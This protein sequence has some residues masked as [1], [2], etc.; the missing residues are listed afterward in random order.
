MEVFFRV[1]EKLRE[2]FFS[3]ASDLH[4]RTSRKDVTT[5]EILPLV[6]QKA[7]V[8]SSIP[9]LLFLYVNSSA[10]KFCEDENYAKDLQKQ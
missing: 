10:K 9:E 6:F 5:K 7:F 3:K 1:Q 4:Q 2:I 8:F